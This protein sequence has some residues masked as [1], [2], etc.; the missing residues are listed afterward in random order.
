MIAKGTRV[1]TC[2]VIKKKVTYFVWQQ[3][4]INLIQALIFWGGPPRPEPNNIPKF[5]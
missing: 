2:K 4:V 1:K 3:I 5:L